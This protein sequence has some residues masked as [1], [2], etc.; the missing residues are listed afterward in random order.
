M[1]N[2]TQIQLQP[3]A[4]LLTIP[5]LKALEQFQKE[6]IKK[7]LLAMTNR[8]INKLSPQLIKREM[9]TVQKLRFLHPQQRMKNIAK[10]KLK[11]TEKRKYSTR[12]QTMKNKTKREIFS[13]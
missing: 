5:V 8:K 1:K 13:Q 11:I 7:I 4:Q 12:A 9:M 6:A 3:K 10:T 2:L